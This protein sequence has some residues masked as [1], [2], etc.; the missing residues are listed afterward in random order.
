MFDGYDYTESMAHDGY[1][2]TPRFWFKP[3][4]TELS[5]WTRTY[6]AEELFIFTPKNAL[7]GL[8]LSY[9]TDENSLLQRYFNPQA[10]LSSNIIDFE[11]YLSSDEYN[12][13][14]N[15]AY[16][17]VD[18]DVYIPLEIS[19]YDCGGDNPTEL[20]LMKRVN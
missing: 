18:K 9:K 2:L 17:H 14:K 16:V 15:G 6:P 3:E 19:G 7:E 1:S 10:Y 20:K 12:L 4:A 11:A 13:I 5:I 8:N